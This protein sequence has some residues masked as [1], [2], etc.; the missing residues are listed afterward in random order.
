MKKHLLILASLVLGFGQLMA[1]TETATFKAGDLYTKVY[2]SDTDHSAT[3]PYTWTSSTPYYVAVVLNGT[4]AQQVT[5][6]YIGFKKGASFT[7]TGTT[8]TTI[9]KVTL[10][11]STN[12]QATYVDVDNGTYAGSGK[13][14]E[15][16]PAEGTEPSSVT[17]TTTGSCNLASI[18][19]EYTAGEGVDDKSTD[20]ISEDIEAVPVESIDS[21]AGTEPYV[22][23][24]K[25]RKYYALNNLGDY[26][27]AGLYPEVSTLKVA[28]G[29]ATTQIE[30]IKA[31]D[32]AYIN[33]NYI[34]K[35][36]TR[37]VAVI[38]A[39]TGAD[40][41]AVYGCGYYSG[42]WKD[43][44]CFFSTNATIDL[45]SETGNKDAM[46]YGPKIVTDMDAATGIMT[47]YEEDGTT[48]IGTINDSPKDA[49]CKTPLYVFAQNKDVPGGGT[50]TDCYNGLVTLYS[51]N[52]YEGETLV[53]QLV[54]AVDPEGKGGLLDKLTGTFYG[55][56]N[57]GT[58]KLSKDGEALAGDAGITVYP[59]KL[60]INTTD[61][62]EYQWNGEAWVD[63]GSVYEAI[64]ATAYRNLNNW[65]TNDDHKGVFEG[66]IAYDEAAGTNH[67]DNYE[68]TG[69]WEPLYYKLEGLTKGETYRVSFN[70]SC[71]Q[72]KSWSSKYSNLP[73]Y[74]R[75]N[76]AFGHASAPSSVGGEI[77]GMVKLPQAQTTNEPYSFTF[78]ADN[79][80]AILNIQFG[81]VDDNAHSPSYYFYFDNLKVEFV[82]YPTKYNFTWSDPNKYTPLAYIESTDAARENVFTTPYYAK[83]NT[84]V[85]I[86]F[87]SYSGG[88]WRAIFSGRNGQSAGNGISLYQNGNQTHFGYFVGG[89]TNDNHAEYPGHNKDI[90]VAATL[91]NLNVD[92]T[93]YPT[94]QTS[95]NSSSRKISIFANPE[96]DNAF[97]GRIYYIT[98]KEDGET[99]YDFQ[100]VMRHDG[101][102]GY[103]DKESATFLTPVQNNWNG[104]GFAK[105]DDQAYVTY[106]ADTRIVIVGSTAQFLPDVQNL[107]DVTFTWSSA[108]E[109]IATVDENGTVTGVKAG[110]VLITATTDA[111]QGWVAS[112]ELTV[113]EPNYLRHDINGVGY[114]IVTGG[115]GWDDSPVANFIDNDVTTKFGTSN[116]SDA[117]AII[118]ASE[119]VAVQQYSLV[120]ANDT[121]DNPARNPRTWK[122]EGSN[123]NQ[124]WTVIDEHNDYD[125]YKVHAV[126]FEEFTFAVNGTETYKFFK[127]SATTGAGF[128]L[129]ELWINEQAHTWGEPT[130]TAATCTVVGKKVWQDAD[131]K[132][133]KTEVLPLAEHTY[134]NGVCSVC[135]AKVAEPVLLANGQTNAYNIK[136]RHEAGTRDGY[137]DIEAGWN[138]A[139]F[140]DSEWDE[141]VMPIGT[142]G[143]DGNAH[144][145]AQYN[146]IWYNEYNTYWFR[147]TFEV[148]DPATFTKLT[149]KALHD[150]DYAVF[151]NGTK[152]VEATGW[153]NGTNWVVTEIDPTLLV[154]GTNVLAMYIEQNFGGAYCDFSLEGQVAAPVAVG[155]AG[156]ATF[157]A[158]FDVDFTGLDV[159]ANAATFDGTYVQLAPVTTVPAG[160]AVVVKADEAGT[161]YAPRTTDAALGAENEL[162]AA[163]ADVTAD[164]TQY[165]LAKPAGDKVGFY[166]AETNTTI[167]AGK[168]Y[169]VITGADVKG[170]YGF[171]SDDATGISGIEMAGEN[172]PIYNVAGQRLGKAQKGIN[173]VGG[174]K[175]LK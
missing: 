34:P 43:R 97:R 64:S 41:K 129:G 48:V 173:I 40:W 160:A 17:F 102:F 133:L 93:D 10:T 92:G 115:K 121:Y 24:L 139:D 35:K 50:Q 72:W 104:Y 59:G 154:K 90:T 20:P 31:Q 23:D 26:E 107:A 126:N 67:L 89:Y 175:V 149:L 134:V 119:P 125:A 145:G 98:L 22:F 132:L 74:V 18:T 76:E 127:F 153:T 61:Q 128:Q 63:L 101:V 58:F 169:L 94:G 105:L 165:V 130:E 30:W 150:D 157:V 103:Y 158:P 147:R 151:L 12:G 60:V 83:A 143:Y 52:L 71:E 37:A 124:N 174:K 87:Q 44:F 13:Q 137:S 32:D 170:F 65:T 135:G 68:G 15:W 38:N 142:N 166:K 140:D 164:G 9:N 79:T 6:T 25:T 85:D 122:L 49:D 51:L 8:G 111:D 54:P 19:V 163:T 162:I 55:S 117:W 144:S 113:S 156:Y 146:T 66:K 7:V 106:E 116:T 99:V 155:E 62:H 46:K 47:I 86:M 1:A 91:G 42:G 152:V 136:F 161:F 11:T 39:E 75:N 16:A 14:G 168:G 70:Y 80:W 56:A 27:E 28:G 108:D 112:Y 109:T 141:L 123:D 159:K 82:N 120:T 21:Y 4:G 57:S 172:A 100:P 77:L 3:L 138:T 88:N 167:A 148:E 110:K 114:A 29:T 5:K 73:F 84:E 53:M 81:V 45:G 96:W 69:G 36:N 171:D 33:L 2:K 118:I 78:T 95:F 131:T